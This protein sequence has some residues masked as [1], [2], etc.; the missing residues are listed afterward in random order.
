MIRKFA[1]ILAEAARRK[2][3]S[4]ELDVALI[5]TRVSP[6]SIV[7]AVPD[8]RILAEMSR[9]IFYAAFSVRVVD[10]KWQSFERAFS[11]FDLSIAASMDDG[12]S[13]R[14]VK[15]PISSQSAEDSRCAHERPIA[16]GLRPFGPLRHLLPRPMAG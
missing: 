3:G 2:G 4:A 6:P 16:A 15:T 13:M 8:D 12:G 11:R 14:S 5:A 10:G 1:D 7:A 9:W